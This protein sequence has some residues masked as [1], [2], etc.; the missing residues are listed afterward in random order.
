MAIVV[1]R[2]FP[3]PKQQPDGLASVKGINHPDL[4]QLLAYTV[5]LRLSAG[6]LVYAAG[7]AEWVEH[8]VVHA[9][10][11]LEV[12]TVDLTASPEQILA[13]V[14]WIADRVKALRAPVVLKKTAGAGPEPI[15]SSAD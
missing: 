14:A 13:D 4:Y 2:G 12:T 8:T 11:R 6:L 3:Q 5:A 10:K 1:A 9:G 15:T 7:E